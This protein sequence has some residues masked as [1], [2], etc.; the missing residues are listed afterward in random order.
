VQLLVGR[1]FLMA[2]MEDNSGLFTRALAS[3]TSSAVH[4]GSCRCATGAV[5]C[6]FWCVFGGGTDM[7]L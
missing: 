7:T 6:L 2:L 4:A 1:I 5:W 3:H